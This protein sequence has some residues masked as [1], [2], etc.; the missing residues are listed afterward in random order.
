MMWAICGPIVLA[1]CADQAPQ[2]CTMIEEARLPVL[3]DAAQPY[4]Q[5]GINDS[6]VAFMIDTGAS[7]SIVTSRLVQNL[8]LP[9]DHERYVMLNGTGGS[10]MAESVRIDKLTLG[11]KHARRADFWQADLPMRTLRGLPGAGL[12]GGDFLA[13]YDGEFDLPDHRVSLYSERGC[14]THFAFDWPDPVYD[15]PFRLDHQTAVML[16]I[17]VDDKPIDAQLDSGAGRTTLDLDA[18]R[19]AGTTAAL[20][21]ADR[22][23]T[24]RG[25]DGNGT[26]TFLHRFDSLALGPE[27]RS[28]VTLAVA[29]IESGPLLGADFLRT[30]RVWISYPHERLWVHPIGK[31]TQL[32][33]AARPG[34]AVTRTTTP[35]T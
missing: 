26:R 18:A 24:G 17:Q 33:P 1:G 21:A 23:V 2:R 9:V 12:F 27:R 25:I 31:V 16:S 14:G 30:H 8:A 5:A 20:L 32:D 7:T 4:V 29:D 11:P 34:A 13:N 22:S 10:V 28:P 35:A 3:N 19:T 15:V 6:P